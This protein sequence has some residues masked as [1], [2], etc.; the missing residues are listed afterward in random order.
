MRGRFRPLVYVSY[1]N[2]CFYTALT[3]IY[4]WLGYTGPW[5]DRFIVFEIFAT[6]LFTVVAMTTRTEL[7]TRRGLGIW[8]FMG[9]IVIS[10]IA[11]QAIEWGF[12]EA[13]F[14]QYIVN[15]WRAPLAV[16]GAL[17]LYGYVLWSKGQAWDDL[18]EDV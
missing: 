15:I 2:A 6:A 7:W 10:Y 3:L 8:N 9:A 1:L 16:G 5:I 12:A 11:S 18:P 17:M 13:P 4:Y 14:P